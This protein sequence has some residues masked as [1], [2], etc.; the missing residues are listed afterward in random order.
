MDTMGSFV[1]LYVHLVF[2]TKFRE[3]LIS[4]QIESRLKKYLAGIGRKKG[5]SVI[6]SGGMEDHIHIL[7]KL[8][9]TKS[10]SKIIQ[11]LKGSSSKWVND[12]FYEEDRRFKWQGGYSAFSVSQSNVEK[13][14]SYINTQKKHHHN[15]SFEEENLKLIQKHQD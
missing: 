7:I 11:T 2:A 9:A 14:K 1:I 8:P 6:T 15:Y 5:F 4:P 13:V 12:T 3:P 10:L